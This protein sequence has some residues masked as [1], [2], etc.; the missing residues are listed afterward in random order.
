MASSSSPAAAAAGG[1]TPI[2]FDLNDF[3]VD[4]SVAGVAAP[5]EI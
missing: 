2:F 3:K 5:F 1:S 4:G